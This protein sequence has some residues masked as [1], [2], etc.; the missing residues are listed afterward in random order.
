MK[1]NIAI[2]SVVIVLGISLYAEEGRF[3]PIDLKPYIE[4]HERV[5]DK[6]KGTKEKVPYR[7]PWRFKPKTV[8][9]EG[10]TGLIEVAGVPFNIAPD[11]QGRWEAVDVGKSKWRSQEKDERTLSF[12]PEWTR[13]SAANG[14]LVLHLP[15][16]AY[17]RAHVLAASVSD[18]AREPVLTLRAGAFQNRG[19]LADVTANVPALDAET[20][21]AAA[22]EIPGTFSG[23]AAATSRGRLF[24][25]PVKIPIGELIKW[26]DVNQKSA[27]TPPLDV[28]LTSR[29]RVKVSA[30]DPANFSIMPLGLPSAVQVFAITF[31]R[32]PVALEVAG[33]STWNIFPNARMAGMD[34]TVS[35]MTKQPQEIRLTAE[36]YRA[37]RGA[38]KD[39]RSQSWT[40]ALS[41]GEKRTV[42]HSPSTEEFGRFNYA[43]A[44]KHATR[45]DLLTHHTTFA[46]LPQF[47][48]APLDERTKSRF[49]VWWWNGTHTTQ[50]G[51]VGV[52]AMDW[53]GLGFIH[54][55]AGNKETARLTA[56]RGVRHYFADAILCLHEF[57]ISGPQMMQY[58]TLMTGEPRYKLNEGEEAR[59]QGAWK[60]SIAKCK[61]TRAE[62]PGTEIIFGNSSFN[63]IDEFLYRKFPSELFDSLGHEACALM[64]MPERQPELAALQEA[65]WFKRALEE[66]GYKQPLTG[67][68]EGLYHAT[69]PGNHSEQA[70]ADLYVRDMLHDV[71]YGFSRICPA[72]MDDVGNGYYYSNWGAS[73]LVTRAPD[74]HPKRSYVAYAVAAHLLSDADFVRA[75]PVGSHSA[76]C[77][78]FDRRRGDKLFACWTLRGVR[79]MTLRGK[80]AGAFKKRVSLTE[81]QG[82]VSELAR[83]KGAVTF[84]VSPSPVFIEGI[85]SCREVVLGP[86]VYAEL[87]NVKRTPVSALDSLE[88]WRL[89]AEPNPDLDDANFDMARQKGEFD[90]SSVAGPG[91]GRC[92]QFTFKRPTRRPPWVPSYQELALEKPIEIPGQPTALG[93]YVRGNSGWGRVN[94]ELRDAKGE[95]WLS[96]GMPNAW[97]ANDEQSVSYII[98]DGWRWMEIPLPGHYAGGFH[99]PRFAN[100]RHDDGD[101]IVDYPLSLTGLSVEQRG[102]IVYVTEMVEASRAPV[103]LSNLMAVYGDPEVVDDWESTNDPSNRW[104]LYVEQ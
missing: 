67:C 65:Y 18:S 38:G 9:P 87:P 78:E 11:A 75:V 19:Y 69:S 54:W 26:L 43:V 37:A 68:A 33:K 8:F 1:P 97:N 82:N 41:P 39:A 70:Q 21:E 2:P 72:C 46:R 29:L 90:V 40:L 5:I 47:P 3:L 91:G 103:C 15:R 16:Q 80:F 4:G 23:P 79:S 101:A 10:E 24:V 71:A 57:N 49:C 22:A 94:L 102:K 36:W 13:A 84:D 98:H 58:P 31:D 28:Q 48:A 88:G 64:R 73:G 7:S 55:F 50:G 56:E 92:L 63:G 89:I 14:D 83:T 44:L 35:N 86:P 51:N 99:W 76:Y 95:R 42:G 62:K 17:F 20:A 77:L 53:L 66:Y 93:L 60:D 96:T 6:K 85:K 27:A 74:V 12:Y 100:W 59:F 45:G 25:V 30:P 34:L 81:Q 52:D 61:K 104:G 32:S